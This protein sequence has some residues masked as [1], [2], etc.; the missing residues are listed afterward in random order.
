LKQVTGQQEDQLLDRLER[1]GRAGLVREKHVGN[2]PYYVFADEQIRE[3][4]YNEQSLIRRRKL[5]A[6]IAHTM[7]ELYQHEKESHL[8]ELA[9]HYIQAGEVAKA[10]EFSLLAG[11]RA[12][13]LH[14]QPEAKKHYRNVID[15]LDDEKQAE[16]L[17]ALIKIGDTSHLLGEYQ[18]CVRYYQE[19][20]S[21]AGELKQNRTMAQ[22]SSKIGYAHW[23]LGNDKD[24]A[25]ESYKQGLSVLGEEKDTSEEA[26]ICANIARLHAFTGEVD[27]GLE[28]CQRSLDVARKLN[29]T[30]MVAH[31]L[32]TQARGT[33]PNKNNRTGILNNIQ[34]SM[35][36][37][38][39]HHVEDPVCRGYLHLGTG[40]SLLMNDYARAKETHMKGLEYCKKNGFLYWEA[41][42]GG[43]ISQFAYIPLGEWDNAI[44]TAGRSFRVASELGGLLVPFSLVP[45]AIAHLFRGNIERAEE[46][47]DMAEP[48]A[49][50]SGF[51]EIT[52]YLL[53]TRGRLQAAKREPADAERSLLKAVDQ[54]SKNSWTCH[55]LEAYLEL[56]KLYCDLGDLVKA[57]EFREK[58]RQGAQDFDEKGAYAYEHWANGLQASMTQDWVQAQKDYRESSKIWKE[59]QNPYYYAQTL[60]GL[61]KALSK[62]GSRDEADRSMTEVKSV[63]SRLGAR[64]DL[65]R[66]EA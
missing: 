31:A 16:K 64:I 18:E 1:A 34:D 19:A 38:T 42:I 43:H 50:K 60:L 40:F 21:I 3:F 39:E 32:Q 14:A 29:L 51:T 12:A 30:D 56:V 61:A 45:L 37:A 24:A 58:I 23:L 36:M 41:N 62:T 22:L 54:G 44:E 49:E 13:K 59:L 10:S 11:D 15:L 25:F 46:C 27:T 7:E 20:I 53:L 48:V 5:H 63:L 26:A 4:L 35:K 28:W 8:E 6:K 33:R 65:A 52:Y 66:I 57:Q 17:A 55:P 9:Y 2:N 47:L